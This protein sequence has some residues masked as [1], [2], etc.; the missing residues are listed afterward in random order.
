M[1]TEGTTGYFRGLFKNTNYEES[2]SSDS[3]Q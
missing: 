3:G 2:S 1:G